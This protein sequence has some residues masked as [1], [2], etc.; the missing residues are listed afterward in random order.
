MQSLK[1]LLDTLHCMHGPYTRPTAVKRRH[2]H[3]DFAVCGLNCPSTTKL[4]NLKRQDQSVKSGKLCDSFL[5]AALRSS[6]VSVEINVSYLNSAY[7]GEEV[8][9][10]A[11][12]LR[13]GKVVGVANV[14]LRKKKT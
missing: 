5:S 6:G 2:K 9:V 14:E 10:E 12:A 7:P 3:A 8:E 13:V 4:T 11:K 1:I